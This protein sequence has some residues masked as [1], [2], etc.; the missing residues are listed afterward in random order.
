MAPRR[1]VALGLR[2]ALALCCAVLIHGV[3]HGLGSRSFLW[4]SPGHLAMMFAAG[5]LFAGIAIPL[6]LAGP[7]R[8]RRR[9]LA[10]VQAALGPPGPRRFGADLLTQAALAVGLLAPE[11]MDIA[12]DRLAIALLGGLVAMLC[13]TILLKKGEKRVIAL[14]IELAT[15]PPAGTPAPRLSRPVRAQRSSEPYH[16]FVPNRPPPVAA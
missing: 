9:R 13:S 7:A 11:G 6:G 12:P 5:G 16:L 15:V 10:L 14:L 4:D 2:G 1:I 3:I 8:E